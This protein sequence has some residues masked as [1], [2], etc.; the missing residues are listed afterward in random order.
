MRI[1]PAP[2]VAWPAAARPAATAAALPPLEPPQVRS[3]FQGLRVTPQCRDS[4]E[5]VMASSGRVVLP[6]ITAP[7]VAQPAHELGVGGCAV[8][9][10]AGAVGGVLAGDV[11]VVLHGH[12]H[13]Q[14]RALLPRSA[15]AIGLLGLRQ[16][17]FRQHHPVAVE[18]RVDALDALQVGLGELP[19]ADL[20]GAHELRLAGCTG[21]G[22]IGGVHGARP[23]PAWAVSRR[24]GR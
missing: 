10:P 13:P 11:G 1:E 5:P 22:Q 24:R 21:E 16:C 6:R 9:E 14:Q 12:G 8:G 23:Y 7:A 3:V 18:L 2:S 4:V 20:A 19:R 15:P 17:P